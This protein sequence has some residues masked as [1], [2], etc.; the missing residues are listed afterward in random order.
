MLLGMPAHPRLLC[1]SLTL[2]DS[3]RDVSDPPKQITNG[4]GMIMLRK[5]GLT[6]PGEFHWQL[7]NASQLIDLATVILA[8][9]FDI[10]LGRIEVTVPWVTAGDDY[11]I[12]CEYC[13]IGRL[14]GISP[15]SSSI[16]RLW[17]LQPRVHDFFLSNDWTLSIYDECR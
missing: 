14:Y 11:Q 2:A 5:G 1:L 13:N 9:G 16:W 7:G 10:L 15:S 17:K 8:D 3:R 12:V 4:I 6:T